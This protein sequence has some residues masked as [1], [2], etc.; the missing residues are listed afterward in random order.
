MVVESFLE[1]CS[2][3]VQNVIKQHV[4]TS[5]VETIVPE[6]YRLYD[7]NKTGVLQNPT[8]VFVGSHGAIFV[9]DTTKGKVFS[10]RLHYPVDVSEVCSS[11]EQPISV[12]YSGGVLYVAEKIN[13]SVVCIDIEENTVLKPMKMTVVQLQKHVSP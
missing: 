7:G 3:E 1:I 11:L 9:A 6:K 8:G 12:A 13:G 5:V 2:P 4:K 10:A